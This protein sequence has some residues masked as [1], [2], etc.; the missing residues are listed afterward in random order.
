VSGIQMMLMAAGGGVVNPLAGGTAYSTAFDTATAGWRFNNDGTVSKR[1]QAT[2]TTD[3]NW[4]RPPGG[5]PGGSYWA[6]LTVN[7]GTG[8]SGSAVGSWIAI[9]SVPQWTLSRSTNG[10]TTGTYTIQIA[11]DAAGANILASGTYIVTVF[12]DMV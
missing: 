12:R 4:F 5:T 1:L 10:T 7:S 2:F 3:H 11:S 8:P 6:R 9:S